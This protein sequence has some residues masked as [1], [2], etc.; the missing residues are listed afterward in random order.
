MARPLGF[1]PRLLQIRSLLPC[2]I[3]RWPHIKKQDTKITLKEWRLST[4]IAVSVFLWSCPRDLNSKPS[5]YKSDAL[6]S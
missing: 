5:D 6:T 1:E 2:P 3:R 4:I